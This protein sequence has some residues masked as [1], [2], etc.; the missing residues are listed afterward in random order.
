[1]LISDMDSVRA[2]DQ[3]LRIWIQNWKMAHKQGDSDGFSSQRAPVSFSWKWKS[4][5]EV[6]KKFRIFKEKN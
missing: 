1:V 6:K 3:D 5:V 2:A 4:F